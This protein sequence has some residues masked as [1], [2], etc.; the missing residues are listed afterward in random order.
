MNTQFRFWKK[1][2]AFGMGAL[3]LAGAVM[4]QAEWTEGDT[5]PDLGA[6]GLEG[7]LPSLEGKV[8][9]IDFWASWCGPC[10]A[11]FPSIE[12]LYSEKKDAGFQVIAVSVDSSAAAKDKFIDRV[13]PSFAIVWDEAQKLVAEAGIEVMP[14]SFLVDEHGRIRKAHSGWRKGV[15][16]VELAEEIET[17][18]KEMN[19][20]E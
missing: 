7:E 20:G 2:K 18:L 11:A 3:A 12:K 10:K 6:F 19:G 4:A 1:A 14:T 16:E 9:Y 13:K 15:S 17:L 8:T 5:V